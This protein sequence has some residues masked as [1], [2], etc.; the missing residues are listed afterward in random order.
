MTNLFLTGQ[1]GIGKS[2]ILQEVLEK[3]NLSIGG[4]ITEKVDEDNIRTFTVKSL[5]DGVE[6]YTIGKVNKKNGSRI[7]IKNLLA[8]EWFQFL[9]KALKIEML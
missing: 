3:L 4:Y 2:T 9:I 5:Y 1:V 8:L 6:K 7:F